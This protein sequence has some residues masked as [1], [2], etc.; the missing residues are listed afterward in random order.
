DRHAGGERLDADDA[1]VVLRGKDEAA[2]RREKLALRRLIDPPGEYDV[3]ARELLEGLALTPLTDNDEPPAGLRERAHRDVG[4]LVRGEPSD[5]QPV[6]ATLGAGIERAHVDRR[7]HH[8]ALPTGV[9]ADALRGD[10]RGRDTA[11]DAR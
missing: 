3:I 2:R 10:P 4:A 1:E 6:V 8:P 5:E 7:V 11:I 9:A